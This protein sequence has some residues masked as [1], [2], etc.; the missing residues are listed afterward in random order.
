[1]EFRKKIINYKYGYFKQ[2]VKTARKLL[3][4]L[5]E[6]FSIGIQ[7][8]KK[9]NGKYRMEMVNENRGSK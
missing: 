7:I 8:L 3:S 6:Y 1:M 2:G 4:C 9:I 5:S